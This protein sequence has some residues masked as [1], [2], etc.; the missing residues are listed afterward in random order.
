MI[1]SLI[2]EMLAS[3]STAMR[4]NN[5]FSCTPVEDH[6]QNQCIWAIW[7]LSSLPSKFIWKTLNVGYITVY[8]GSENIQRKANNLYYLQVASFL[9]MHS[10][11]EWILFMVYLLIFSALHWTI[12]KFCSTDYYHSVWSDYTQVYTEGYHTNRLPNFGATLW[13][14]VTRRYLLIHLE[15]EKEFI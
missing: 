10:L 3:S 8:P 7:Y 6:P 11:L 12:S 1:F 4:R 15:R 9:I 13:V 2:T 5:P 14:Q